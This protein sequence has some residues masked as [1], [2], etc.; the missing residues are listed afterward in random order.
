MVP[1]AFMAYQLLLRHL[2]SGS[3]HSLLAKVG[4]NTSLVGSGAIGGLHF[5]LEGYRV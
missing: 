2:I 5:T 4:P 3:T 1:A